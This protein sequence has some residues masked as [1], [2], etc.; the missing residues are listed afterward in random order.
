MMTRASCEGPRHGDDLLARGREVLDLLGRRDLR[1]P[2]AP[3]QVARL[4]HRLPALREPERRQLV[5]EVDV[6]RDGQ[7]VDDVELLVHRRHAVLQRRHGV[8]DG[9]GLAV[10]QDP[11]LG[12]L[13]STG[14][15]LDERGLAGPVLA[16]ETVDLAREDLEIDAVERTSPG[17]DLDDALHLQERLGRV[18]GDHAVNLANLLTSVNHKV[19]VFCHCYHSVTDKSVRALGTRWERS[20]RSVHVMG[21]GRGGRVRQALHEQGCREARRAIGGQGSSRGGRRPDRRT[22]VGPPPFD[23]VHVALGGDSRVPLA[24]V[25]Q[26]PMTRPHGTDDRR[27]AP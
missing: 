3:E 14:E 9:D 20:R 11:A 16:E 4:A 10:E 21:C 12:G 15:H 25:K 24:I 7:A 23:D 2:E 27:E 5:P 1:V 18:C 26:K 19:V 22:V 6:L 17:E 8:G 13:V